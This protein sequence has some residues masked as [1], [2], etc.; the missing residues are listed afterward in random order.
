MITTGTNTDAPHTALDDNHLEGY[1]LEWTELCD[2]Q[3]MHGYE[4]IV[5]RPERADLKGMLKSRFCTVIFLIGVL[6]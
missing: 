6:I 5:R 4:P 1:I 2:T 3:L